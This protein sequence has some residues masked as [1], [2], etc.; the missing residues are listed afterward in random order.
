MG[1]DWKS[2]VRTVAP[3]V[4][5]AI[6]GPLGGMA[7]NVLLDTLGIKPS[8]NDQDN[9]RILEE[10]LRTASPA[11]LLALKKAD[12]D[13]E[14]K[15]AEIG[16]DKEK[17]HQQDRHSARQ[18]EVQVGGRAAPALA[19]VTIVG[20]FACVGYVLSGKVNLSGEQGVIIG[21]LIGYVSAKADQVVSYYFG[22]SSG[23]DNHMMRLV[24]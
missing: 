3:T 20:F 15:M 6:G 23:Q 12:Q 10:R 24:K 17:L 11:D 16:L 19:T 18:R 8:T 22:S 1:F 21:T 4:G 13:F 14:A 7:T 2:L 5:S 9:D